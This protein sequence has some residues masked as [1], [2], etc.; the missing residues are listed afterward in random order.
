MSSGDSLKHSPTETGAPAETAPLAPGRISSGM[1]WLDMILR[2]GIPQ[3]R[4]YLISGDPGTGK[5]TLSLQ[6]LLEGVLFVSLA[7]TRAELVKN[8]EK[9]CSAWPNRTGWT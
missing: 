7:E 2:G 9:V 5:T 4:V 3:N 8:G 1:Q 6:F